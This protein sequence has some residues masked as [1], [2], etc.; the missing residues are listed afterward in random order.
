M[1]TNANAE[2]LLTSDCHEAEFEDKLHSASSR[3]LAEIVLR[4]LN[5]QAPMES[6]GYLAI[7][8]LCQR[9]A[10]P[11][12]VLLLA[13]ALAQWVIC[14]SIEELDGSFLEKAR[15]LEPD[16]KRVL[17]A[18]LEKH[19]NIDGNPSQRAFEQQIIDQ[20]L[21]QYP[22]EAPAREAEAILTQSNA[23]LPLSLINRLPDPLANVDFA[24][25]L[26][27]TYESG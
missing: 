16:N 3:V 21:Q 2:E 26:L 7:R 12:E 23:S 13:H 5:Q 25:L 10:P 24:T 18:L 1:K 19:P 15:T 22:E 6:L 20:F 9:N 8:E 17:Y 11:V 4:A 27:K 14:A